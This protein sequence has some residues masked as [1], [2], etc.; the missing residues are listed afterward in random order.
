MLT[1][2]QKQKLPRLF[3]LH[4]LNADGVPTRADF[5][6]YAR[7]IA[8]MRGWGSD[9][10]EYRQL[11][12]R[13]TTFWDGLEEIASSMGTKQVTLATWFEYWDR[14]L[15]EPGRYEQVA[16]PIGRV[17]FT[18]LD[19]DGDGSVTAEEYADLY[20]QGGLDPN[21]AAAAFARLD[22]DHD[23]RLSVDEVMQHADQFFWSEDPTEPGNV[24][25]GPVS[26]VEVRS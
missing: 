8:A 21:E 20:E 22:L 24:L 19:R 5:D 13:F 12:A 14:L 9:S 25:F 16:A 10:E 11:S 2:F 1:E 3:A 17:L 7:R 23:G 18:M 15:G 6:E 26:G 4:D